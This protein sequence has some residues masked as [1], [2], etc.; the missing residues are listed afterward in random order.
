MVQS[1]SHPLFTPVRMGSL[2]LRNRILMAPLTRMRASHLAELS[3]S[4]EKTG[5]G[6]SIASKEMN[7]KCRCALF[8]DLNR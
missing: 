4:P 7:H 3:G 5:V 6:G 1:S 2:E 8:V